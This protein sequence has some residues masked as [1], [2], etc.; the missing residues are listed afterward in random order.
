MSR[1]PDIAAL[2]RDLPAY[3]RSLGIV[4]EA[5]E[6]GSPVLA[7][8]FGEIVEGRP[9]VFHGG[10]TSGL[11]ENAGYAAL[12]AELAR[13]GREHRLKPINVTV[14]FLSAAKSK[15]TYA[16]GRVLRLGRRNAN[17]EVE[18][19][20]DDRTRPVATAVMNVLMGGTGPDAAG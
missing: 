1:D 4:I 17:I 12:R 10:A 6:D 16:R 13:A 7:I 14:Q 15:P 2:E 8:P 5:M 3:A 20:Q 11:L 19:W 18:A 9:T